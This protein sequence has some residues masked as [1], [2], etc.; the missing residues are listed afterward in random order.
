VVTAAVIVIAA[1]VNVAVVTVTVT[2]VTAIVPLH[3]CC[4]T[5][6]EGFSAAAIHSAPIL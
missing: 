3:P 5:F 4:Y 2:V 1:V 6:L